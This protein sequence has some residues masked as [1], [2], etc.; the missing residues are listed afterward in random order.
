MAEILKLQSLLAK[1]QA[2]L[3]Q[4][5]KDSNVVGTVGYTQAYALY[6][7]EDM[8]AKHKEGKE[9][10]FLEKPARQL[11]DDGT[12]GGIVAEATRRGSTMMQAITLACLRLQR[13]SQEIVPVDTGALRASAFTRVETR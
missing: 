2:R 8:E 11:S 13:A 4:A 9:A 3:A 6:V 5:A 1:L 7:H 10:K 12:L